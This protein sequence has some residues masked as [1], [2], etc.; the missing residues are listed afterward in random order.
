MNTAF[1]LNL[2]K[3]NFILLN[4][5]R[6]PS[7]SLALLFL[8]ALINPAFGEVT[9]LQ[10]NN[11][12]FIMGDEIEFSGTVEE[13]STGLVTIVIRDPNNEFVLLTQA[14][15]NYDNT[16]QKSV[17]IES[18]FTQNGIYN[19]TGFIL[20]MTKGITSEF[21][22]SLNENGFN[23]E[24]TTNVF[25]SETNNDNDNIIIETNDNSIETNTINSDFVDSN[26]DPSYYLQRYYSEPAYKSWFD[27]NYPGQTIEETVGY[28]ENVEKI[29]STVN[30]II[31][32]EI[33]PEVQASS[34][35]VPDQNEADN[36]DMAKISLSVAVL[37]ILFGVV[38]IV[39]RQVDDNSRQIS[40]NKD[41]IRKI[42]ESLRSKKYNFSHGRSPSG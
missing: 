1:I 26:K 7:Y 32:K 6:Y 24:V 2:K 10:T 33:I 13:D 27:K 38:Y 40:I 35:V 37:V 8:V 29:K 18:R 11:N 15:I 31:D 25:V 20:N 4:K 34:I 21:I 16:F 5:K 28:T 23:N 42:S 3:T 17:G 14:T 41:T 39:K 36:S 9:S 30:E 12:S 19:S 22:V